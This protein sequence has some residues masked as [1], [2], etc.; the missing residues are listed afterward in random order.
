[1]QLIVLIIGIFDLYAINTLFDKF[2]FFMFVCKLCKKYKK[3][4][5][6]KSNKSAYVNNET[7][8]KLSLQ[9]C[10]IRYVTLEYQFNTI[11]I[12]YYINII[13]Y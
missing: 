6:K 13:D 10:E 9:T 7:V 3:I 5:K 8:S 1:M 12:T 4:Q 11:K 2:Y